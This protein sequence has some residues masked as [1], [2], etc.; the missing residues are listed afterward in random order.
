MCVTTNPM[1]RARELN[2]NQQKKIPVVLDGK[3]NSSALGDVAIRGERG[4]NLTS[5]LPKF[6]MMSEGRKG[7]K[8]GTWRRCTSKVKAF[9][10][11]KQR[12]SPQES[13]LMEVCTPRNLTGQVLIGHTAVW[14]SISLQ[15][16]V[17]LDSVRSTHLSLET[18]VSRVEAALYLPAWPRSPIP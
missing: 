11:T 6:S 17:L 13:S 2:Q 18:Q 7:L 8:L 9:S 15:S 16:T 3:L 5:Q 10:S 4:S 12:G 14:E 1:H